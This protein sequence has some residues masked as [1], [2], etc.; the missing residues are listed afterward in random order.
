M[1]DEQGE[2][3]AALESLPDLTIS[4]NREAA[5][6][7]AAKAYWRGCALNQ[8]ALTE[9]ATLVMALCGTIDAMVTERLESVA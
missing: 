4:A 2:L 5:F 7:G 8:P 3:E 1:S 9:M 6:A